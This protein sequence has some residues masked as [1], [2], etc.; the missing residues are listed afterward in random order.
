MKAKILV[1][2]AAAAVLFSAPAE[3]RRLHFWWQQDYAPDY[4]EPDYYAPDAYSTDYADQQNLDVQEQF[5]QD[6]YDKYM[7]EMRHP[8][9]KRYAASY[10]DPQVDQPVYKKAP[11]YKLKKKAV[12]VVKRPVVAKPVLA[13]RP[14]QTASIAKRLDTP[15]VSKKIDCGKGA[16]I[17]SGYGFNDVATKSC[18]GQTLVYG[19]T[20]SGKNFE[21]EVNSANGELMNV[22]RL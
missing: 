3:A 15:A 19:A 14:V 18:A 11:T 2:A 7:R 9:H 20:R 6:Q 13:D 22:K 5:N 10:Y 4:V 16:A 12:A 21:V 8:K 1:I 17:V